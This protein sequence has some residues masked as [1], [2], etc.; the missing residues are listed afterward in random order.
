MPQEKV[1]IKHLEPERLP[2]APDTST[3]T[4][5]SDVPE[6][7]RRTLAAVLASQV[8]EASRSQAPR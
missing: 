2:P 6:D 8:R 4:G 3:D 1:T 7:A 5:E